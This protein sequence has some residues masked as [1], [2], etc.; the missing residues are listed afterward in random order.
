MWGVCGVCV[1]CVC[2]WEGAAWGGA[3]CGC[4]LCSMC[5]CGGGPTCCCLHNTPP[6]L[7]HTQTHFGELLVLPQLLWVKVTVVL[8]IRQLLNNL[9]A[10]PVRG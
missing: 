2:G 1:G 3:C 10:L 7:T 4:L 9:L 5:G 8:V 6:P